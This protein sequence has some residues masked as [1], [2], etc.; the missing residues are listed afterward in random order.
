MMV[1]QQL[2]L[3]NNHLEVIPFPILISSPPR[4][5]AVVF[6]A[7]CLHVG[8]SN[9]ANRQVLVRLF[10]H[11]RS[12]IV[13]TDSLVFATCCADVAHSFHWPALSLE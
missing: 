11:L 9:D 4:K 2:I 13:I 12:V 5:Q 3:P 1:G 10:G 8:S 7:R 6:W